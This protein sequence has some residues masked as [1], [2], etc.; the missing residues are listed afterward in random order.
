MYGLDEEKKEPLE[1]EAGQEERAEEGAPRQ[2]EA[3][4]EAPK[5]ES[6]TEDEWRSALETAVRQRDEYLNLAQRTQADFANFRRRNQQIR[7]DAYDDGLR[8]ALTAL[9]PV[10]D[11]LQRALD[12]AREAGDESPLAQGVSMIEKQLLEET[13][14][15]GMEEIPALGE[16][17]D[18]E[19]HNAVMR[20]EEGEPGTILE[21]FQ[22][23]YRVKGR[24]I[25]HPM[26]KVAVEN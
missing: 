22:K 18:P 7:A 26:V 16:K 23:G 25:R 6:A 20:S 13:S 15:L 14:K 4:G 3:Q 10:I 17:F 1:P 21:V 11:N 5:F 9:L 12:A 24:I 19:L 8:E 2:E